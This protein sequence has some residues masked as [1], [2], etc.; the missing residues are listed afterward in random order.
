MGA[1]SEPHRSTTSRKDAPSLSR[2]AIVMRRMPFATSR[3]TI[4]RRVVRVIRENI[5]AIKMNRGVPPQ[6]KDVTLLPPTS[7]LA[8]RGSLLSLGL[9]IEAGIRFYGSCGGDI[10]I[11]WIVERVLF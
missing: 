5:G 7:E 2:S 1:M 11:C 6:A 10:E 3:K 9:G 8:S 4:L